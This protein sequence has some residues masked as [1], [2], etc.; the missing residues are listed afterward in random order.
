MYGGILRKQPVLDLDDD[1][2]ALLGDDSRAG[3][4]AVDG[5]C[6]LLEA[7]GRLV[8][9]GDIPPVMP[10]FRVGGEE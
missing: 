7:V 6:E 4:L 10:D 8:L 2:I 5:D 9:V 3:G 1:G